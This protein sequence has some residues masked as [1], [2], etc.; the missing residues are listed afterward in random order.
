MNIN[1]DLIKNLNLLQKKL[2]R[3]NRSE[4]IIANDSLNVIKGHPYYLKTFKSYSFKN[5][6]K[7]IIKYFLIN[8]Y[9]LFSSLIYYKNQINK[10]KTNIDC[11]IVSHLLSSKKN[12]LEKNKDFYF[13]EFEK[14]K[15]FK[16]KN[17]LMIL[18]NH[19]KKLKKGFYNDKKILLQNY[20]NF[21][22]SVYIFIRLYFL[23]LK[24]FIV[25]LKKKNK[26]FTLLK[27]VALEFVNP[28]TF[29][30]LILK[31][32]LEDIILGK[33]I[34]KIFFT[35]EGFAWERFLCEIAKRNN[36]N[37]ITF[38]YQFAILIKNQN[39][40]FSK[41][42]SRYYPD[43]VLTSGLI[44]Y[45]ILKKKFS[46]IILIGSSRFMKSKKK[47]NYKKKICLV[48]P[49]GMDTEC[50][51]LLDFI[52]S[53]ANKVPKIKFIIRLHPMT[54]ISKIKKILSKKNNSKKL[55]NLEISSK[56][57]LFDLHRS[58]ICL[59]RGSTSAI[60]AAQNGIMPIYYDLNTNL[61]IDPMFQIDKK[62]RYVKNTNDF[63]RIVN[64]S[65][66]K[67]KLILK[68]ICKLSQNYFVK[69]N[70]KKLNYILNN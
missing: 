9:Y 11:L 38:G 67:R 70:H 21:N 63:E 24:Y 32:N 57:L 60:T 45:K 16:K 40:L 33:N 5:Y 64:L 44:N 14:N 1:T 69:F 52:S 49:E 68:K 55:N 42:P 19:T 51:I 59:H 30:N 43:K 8:L 20:T 2:L 6:I 65:E 22:H 7:L 18:M 62:E 26:E 31:K 36:K 29:K 12:N 50:E 23:F 25:S 48:V 4:Y 53:V 41:I 46:N 56:S 35:F 34:K 27:I 66:K 39:S 58:T 13:G 47:I 54:N 61:N 15:N 37:T 3:E 28:N 17:N 10:S